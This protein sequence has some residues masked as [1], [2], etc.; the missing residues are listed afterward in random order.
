[1]AENLL[2]APL[3]IA[4]VWRCDTRC[5][6]KKV[7]GI[8]RHGRFGAARASVSVSLSYKLATQRMYSNNESFFLKTMLKGNGLQRT[9]DESGRESEFYT[10]EKP[11]AYG[12]SNTAHFWISSTGFFPLMNTYG[13]G[14]RILTAMMMPSEYEKEADGSLCTDRPLLT[15]LYMIEW[16]MDASQKSKSE[17]TLLSKFYSSKHYGGGDV[18]PVRPWNKFLNI[19]QLNRFLNVIFYV[20]FHQLWWCAESRI[21]TDFIWLVA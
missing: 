20:I 13:W 17:Q 2:K 19:W 8:I 12:N 1:M 9:R 5:D 6:L 7:D 16:E 4:G 18:Q 3:N 15:L 11:D 10:V 21:N 14:K